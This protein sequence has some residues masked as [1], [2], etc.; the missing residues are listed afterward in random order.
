MIHRSVSLRLEAWV[1]HS[2]DSCYLWIQSTCANE[3]CSCAP[4]KMYEAEEA[5]F[6]QQWRLTV[7]IS[8]GK[9][10]RG[11]WPDSISS[12]SSQLWQHLSDVNG[13]YR[14]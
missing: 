9:S 8:E 12:D 7:L 3:I 14:M 6:L 2:T 13:V 4:R 11:V 5:T 10:I 1:L